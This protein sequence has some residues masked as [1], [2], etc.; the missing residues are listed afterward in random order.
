[1]NPSSPSVT[2]SRTPGMSSAA[3]GRP[4]AIASRIARWPWSEPE[5]VKRKM[6]QER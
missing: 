2:R 6:S 5:A 4:L 1:M 3:I